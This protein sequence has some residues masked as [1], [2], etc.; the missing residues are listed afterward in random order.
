MSTTAV[1]GRRAPSVQAPITPP[2]KLRRRPALVALGVAL[3]AL[4]GLAAAFLVTS[5]TDTE[6]VLALRVDVDRGTVIEAGDLVVAQ[7]GADPALNP[8]AADERDEIVGQRAA[9]DLS[10]GSLLADGSVT[11][12]VIPA[13][14]ESLVG[15]A[16]TPAQLPGTDLRSGDVVRIVNTPRA[17]EEVD[18]QQPLSIGATVVATRNVADLGQIVVDV[19]VPTGDAAQLAALVGTG[20]IVLVVDGNQ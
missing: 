5:V 16:L 8:V 17:Q 18:D 13:E 7:V 15:V 6:S 9:R 20:R 14:G 4:G 2:P 12:E 11:E 3:V 10:A 19:T 1:D